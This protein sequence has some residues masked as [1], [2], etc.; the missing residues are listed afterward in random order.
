[1]KSRFQPLPLLLAA[2]LLVTTLVTGP[3]QAQTTSRQMTEDSQG[4]GRAC[5]TPEPDA[6]S[7]AALQAAVSSWLK[8]NHTQ[9]GGQIKVAFHVI[10]NPSTGEGNIP[11]S[12]IT[13]QIQTLNTEYASAGFSFVLASTSRTGNKKWFTT[14]PGG[15]ERTMKSSLAIDP[16]HRLNV[17]T[18]KPGQSLLGWA[19]FPD[20]YP[21]NST[22]HGVVFHYGSV[23]GG[24]LTAYNEG[25]TLT[26]EVGHY[27]GLY[28]TF[29]GG[30]NAPGDYVDDTPFEA[31]A[32]TG[33][34]CSLQRDTCPSPGLD[35]ISNY[36]DY[37]YDACL[38]NFSAG[39]KTRM[40][41]ITPQYRPSLLNA[42]A[43]AM[44]LAS[45]RPAVETVSAVSFAG[46]MPNPSRGGT[47]LEYAL[48]HAASVSLNLYS[49]SGRL[50]SSIDAGVKEAGAHRVSFADRGVSVGTYFAVLVVDG[51]KYTRTVI[52]Q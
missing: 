25:E 37:S 12:Q 8:Q 23:P 47:T 19:Y 28:H 32:Y 45:V 31:S 18:C 49:V 6:A 30:C 33:G 35:P 16:A 41:A 52:L 44:D 22:M 36:M 14:V 50:V 1:M 40:Q 34:Q 48:P 13:A 10:Y 3:S 29:Q 11:D 4:G 42:A 21:E 26:H 7:A 17:Y 39:Q 46:A 51:Q 5:A 27:L 20:S 24:Y 38:T 2:S 9:A 43:R 15:T